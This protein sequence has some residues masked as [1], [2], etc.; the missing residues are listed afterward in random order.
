M[1]RPKFWGYPPRSAPVGS[2]VA[3]RFSPERVRQSE[4]SS[5]KKGKTGFDAT[6]AIDKSWRRLTN[7]LSG[8]FCASLN[9]LDSTQSVSPIWSLRPTGVRSRDEKPNKD[10]SESYCEFDSLDPCKEGIVQKP[11]YL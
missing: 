8:Q 9:F 7:A 11:S 1:W 3:A 2:M 4:S 5:E 10:E 6:S